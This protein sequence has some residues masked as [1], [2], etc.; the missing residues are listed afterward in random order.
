MG[1]LPLCLRL[2]LPGLVVF[3]VLTLASCSYRYLD[4]SHQ[5]YFNRQKPCLPLDKGDLQ[6]HAFVA[7]VHSLDIEKW[8]LMSID[9]TQYK[10][11]A[12]VGG[13]RFP[14][15]VNIAVDSGGVVTITR[16]RQYRISRVR[17]IRMR[18]VMAHLKKTFLRYR[19]QS[20]KTLLEQVEKYWIRPRLLVP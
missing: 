16:S 20:I 17:A 12:R 1:R 14:T 18:R 13:C 3:L 9:R 2:I 10:V 15:I 8:L 11:V 4:S 6:F 19:C 7:I 5:V